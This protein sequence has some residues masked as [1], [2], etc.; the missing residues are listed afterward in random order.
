MPALANGPKSRFWLAHALSENLRGESIHDFQSFWCC[1][2]SLVFLNLYTHHSNL[3]LHHR[4]AF[5]LYVSIPMSLLLLWQSY[6]NRAHYQFSSVAQSCLTPCNPMDYSM[7][8]FPVHHQLPELAQAHVHQVSDAIQSSHPLSS[9]SPP[10]LNL[11]QHQCLFKW[12]SSSH[13][14][15]KDWSFHF[16]ISP[17]NEYPGLTSF[18]VDRLDLLAVQGNFKSLL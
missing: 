12:V 4:W 14:V 16:S 10:T 13:Q 18:R 7:L 3:C 9:P 1:Q 5:C 17:S 11:S 8:G 2:Q 15:A 6:W